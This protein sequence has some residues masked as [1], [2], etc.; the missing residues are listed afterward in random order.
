MDSKQQQYSYS[1]EKSSNFMYNL[2][3]PK[4]S[5][6]QSKQ[7]MTENMNIP[8]VNKQKSFSK[9]R[10]REKTQSKPTLNDSDLMYNFSSPQK[11]SKVSLNHLLN[12]SFPERQKHNVV[13]KRQVQYQPMFNKERFV[14]AK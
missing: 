4:L 3:Q 1:F 9:S 11:N 13:G 12:F 7:M 8:L 5:K 14:N 2:V 10:N 6:R